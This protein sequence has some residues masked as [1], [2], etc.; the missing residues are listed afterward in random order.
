MHVNSAVE[1]AILAGGSFWG[2]QDLIR[3]RP[4]VIST[5]V[6]YTGGD[7]L[8]RDV[9]EPRHACRGDR[10]RL[11]PRADLVPRPVRALL[12][13]PRS[14]DAEPAGQRH[15]DELSLRDLL[16]D[17][18]QRRVAE[19]TI[20]DVEASGLW[21]GKAVTEVTPAGP[22]WRP[23]PSTR[24]ISSGTRTATRATS[25]DRTGSYRAERKPSPAD[26]WVDGGDR[27]VGDSEIRAGREI[28]RCSV[29][30]GSTIAS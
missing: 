21:P 3:K 13:D 11:R 12:P 23:S 8:R 26:A 10:D 7:N 18:E 17:D 30:D 4:G 28:H 16:L 22:F 27:V 1:K 14:D 20:A 2:M 19:D 5:R 15:R 6:G 25:R 29:V 24:T 9:P